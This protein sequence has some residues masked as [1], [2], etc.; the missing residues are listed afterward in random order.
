MVNVLEVEFVILYQPAIPSPPASKGPITDP[1]PDT[2]GLNPESSPLI[3]T[4]STILE[5]V[6]SIGMIGSPLQAC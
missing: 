6:Y 3:S 5:K 4:S 1:T 2:T